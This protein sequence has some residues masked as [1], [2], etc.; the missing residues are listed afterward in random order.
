MTEYVTYRKNSAGQEFKKKTHYEDVQNVGGKRLQ[1]FGSR[2]ESLHILKS[3]EFEKIPL[4]LLLDYE[5]YF[6]ENGN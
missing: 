2:H 3:A 5:I 1:G 6:F 4:N